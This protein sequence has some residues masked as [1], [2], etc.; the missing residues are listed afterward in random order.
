MRIKRPLAVDLIEETIQSHYVSEDELHILNNILS[1]TNFFLKSSE[2]TSL[3]K[4]LL[5]IVNE[6]NF[7]KKLSIK[8]KKP[9][10]TKY[11]RKQRPLG[12]KIPKE[13]LNELKKQL[14]FSENFNCYLYGSKIYKNNPKSNDYDFLVITENPREQFL[15]DNIDISFITPK[16]FQ[17]RLNIHQI[18][19]IECF[20]LSSD[21]IVKEDFHF[22]FKINKSKL[23]KHSLFSSSRSWKKAKTK[24]EKGEDFYLSQKSIFHSLRILKF[25]ISLLNNPRRLDYQSG[26]IFWNQ[27]LSTNSID[28]LYET[29][30]GEYS[31]LKKDI[32]KFRKPKRKK[33]RYSNNPL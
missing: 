10:K 21:Y 6:K 28:D 22:D 14:D 15:S 24:K 32:R 1:S 13:I 12:H 8:R 30:K 3:K 19:A 20:Y 29:M 33:Y 18:N 31:L 27:V 26:N 25:C 23:I 17:H 16:E 7:Y 4:I 2:F 5:P 11:K 9:Y